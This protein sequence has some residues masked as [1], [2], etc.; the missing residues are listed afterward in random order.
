MAPRRFC[1]VVQTRFS[2]RASWGFQEFPSDWL[3]ERLALLDDYCLPSIAGQTSDDFIWHV[4]CDRETD[5]SILDELERRA[6]EVPQMRIAITGPGCDQP[7]AHVLKATEAGDRAVITTRLD[8]D[9]A[10]ARGYVEAIQTHAE[11]FIG[12]ERQTLLLN[13]PRGFQLDRDSGRLL[14]DWM[15]RSSFHSLF[16]RVS[17]TLTTVLAGNHSRFHEVHP[18]EHD[19][20]IPAWLM[21]IHEG[22]VLNTLRE[23]YTGEADPSRLGEFSISPAET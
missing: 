23:Y 13:F 17:T 15:P 21:V 12:S 7:P 1:H 19:D 2:L 16:E 9:D 8:S 11:E 3:R 5:R 10:I 22:N 4:Y 20:S 6:E 18:T 14:F